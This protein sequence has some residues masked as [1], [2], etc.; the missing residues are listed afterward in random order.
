MRCFHLE[1]HHTYIHKFGLF[2]G[3]KKSNSDPRPKVNLWLNS[4]IS[5]SLALVWQYFIQL[6]GFGLRVP[7]NEFLKLRISVRKTAPGFSQ[8]FTMDQ[9]F[10]FFK[11]QQRQRITQQKR[12]ER[13]D[14]I[15]LSPIFPRASSSSVNIY[16]HFCFQSFF[17]LTS[18]FLKLECEN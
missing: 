18:F 16:H 15:F 6:I 17:M 7:R 8:C 14:D 4:P 11:P 2:Q 5:P 9:L 3:T 10:S 1:L 12:T 13:G